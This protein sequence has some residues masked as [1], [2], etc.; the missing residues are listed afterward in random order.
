MDVIVDEV[1]CVGRLDKLDT[2]DKLRTF[3]QLATRERLS[4]IMLEVELDRVDKLDTFDKLRTP[5]QLVTLDRLSPMMLEMRLKPSSALLYKP[6][7]SPRLAWPCLR[8]KSHVPF[9]RHV[10]QVLLRQCPQRS[11]H[12]IAFNITARSRLVDMNQ[13]RYTQD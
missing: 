6:S 2:S 5:S 3:N 4:P 11:Q 7:C 8:E 13:C 12:T 9:V 1:D 10:S